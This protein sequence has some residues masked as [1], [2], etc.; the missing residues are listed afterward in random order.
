MNR[1]QSDAGPCL[2]CINNCHRE[3]VC[4]QWHTRFG[5]FHSDGSRTGLPQLCCCLTACP[6]HGLLATFR[7]LMPAFRNFVQPPKGVFASLILDQRVWFSAGT[8]RKYAFPIRC[9][10]YQI[11]FPHAPAELATRLQE[12]A[13]LLPTD[14]GATKTE[15]GF[16]FVQMAMLSGR[17]C[18]RCARDGA[19]HN[20][21]AICDAHGIAT[22]V[23]ARLP[24]SRQLTDCH[25]AAPPEE[26]AR[27]CLSP[28]GTVL[29]SALI[30]RA[31]APARTL[32]QQLQLQRSMLLKSRWHRRH[33]LPCRC[34][35]EKCNL[36][37]RRGA[38]I[39]RRA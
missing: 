4:N 16:C 11:Y 18:T 1:H 22:H 8:L 3:T 13:W 20:M 12:H 14:I 21:S 2:A 9:R 25:R 26:L 32:P 33:P 38:A 37:R 29:G 15:I 17:E 5:L 19:D 30:A 10:C 31:R 34:D 28:A 23:P 36:E 27:R 39:T 35:T 7:Q 6:I 24:R